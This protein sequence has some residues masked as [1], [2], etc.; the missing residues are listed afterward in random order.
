MRT[1]IPSQ[2]ILR[3]Y[4][5]RLLKKTGCSGR[6]SGTDD[7]EDPI[8]AYTSALPDILVPGI[9]DQIDVFFLQWT[10]TPH[11]DFCI[12]LLAQ[13]R[14]LALGYLQTAER[15]GDL[16]DLTG[17]NAMNI[18][19]GYRQHKRFLAP[20]IPLEQFGMKP[21]FTILGHHEFQRPHSCIKCPGLITVT[22]SRAFIGAFIALC[23]PRYRDG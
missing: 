23:L 20:L 9:D 5:R 15:L 7:H 22:I 3:K 1:N 8:A 17:C 12:Q 21:A 19:L 16:R 18:H 11:F 4:S 14:H 6:G 10:V 13:L 2:G